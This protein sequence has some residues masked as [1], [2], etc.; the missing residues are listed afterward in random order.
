MQVFVRG[1]VDS[2][3]MDSPQRAAC[4][5]TKSPGSATNYGCEGCRVH[6]DYYCDPEFDVYKFA[7]TKE[8][9]ARIRRHLATLTGAALLKA[10][11]KMG[12][13]PDKQGLPNPFD[14]V[15]VDPV[16]Q[17]PPEILHTDG[18]VS[19]HGSCYVITDSSSLMYYSMIRNIDLAY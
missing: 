2:L 7:R 16:K 12:V 6:R 9:I 5:Q 3:V 11:M 14:S 4:C 8:G 13:T 17:G 19:A 10:S 1:G 18:R 15:H